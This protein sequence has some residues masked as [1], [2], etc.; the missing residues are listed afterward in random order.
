MMKMNSLRPLKVN[1]I[2]LENLTG[3]SQIN[4]TIQEG[5]MAMMNN[6]IW[7]YVANGWYKL[8]MTAG[9]PPQ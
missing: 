6:Q 5:T 7:V 9:T 2:V 4:G 3:R 8:G 1:S